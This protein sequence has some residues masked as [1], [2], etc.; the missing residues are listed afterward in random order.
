[1]LKIA[2]IDDEEDS[3][4]VLSKFIEHYLNDYIIVGTANSVDSAVKLLLSEKP[5]VILLDIQLTDGTGFDILDHFP[6][7]HFKIIF[8]TA[9]DKYAI[10]A[11]N[12]QAINYILKPIGPKEFCKAFDHLNSL[13]FDNHAN[14]FKSAPFKEL[15]NTYNKFTI[16]TFQGFT[17]VKVKDIIRIE[18]EGN[19]STFYMKDGSKTLT[20][21][22]IGHFELL[23]NPT[24]YYRIHQS[25]IINLDCVKSYTNKENGGTITLENGD[26]IPISRRKKD[27][28]LELFM[29]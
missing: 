7:S 21:K 3:I 18:S 14:H 5:D 12:Y 29:R 22:N 24:I 1:M 6:K 26:Q 15:E 28:F 17:N 20:T 8:I 16:P 25:H 11:F 13:H 27:S 10:K 4:V 2:I 9:Y 19:Y 23:L